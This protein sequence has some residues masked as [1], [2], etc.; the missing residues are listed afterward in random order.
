MPHPLRVLVVDDHADAA[1][2][3]AQLLDLYGYEARV[4]RDG[5]AALADAASFPPDVVLLEPRMP[6]M[7]GYELAARL[8]GGAARRPL[9]VAVSWCATAGEHRRSAEAGI[10]LHL[11]KPADPEVLVAALRRF[12]RGPVAA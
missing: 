7:D 3:T 4:A 6:G 9:L 1:A 8:R 10:D 5:P 12:E 2:S 11:D